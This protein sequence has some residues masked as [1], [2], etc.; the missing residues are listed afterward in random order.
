MRPAALL[1]AEKQ[2]ANQAAIHAGTPGISQGLPGAQKTPHG[3]L[4]GVREE[5]L[6]KLILRKASKKVE[7]HKFIRELQGPLH[8]CEPADS[9]QKHTFWAA[10][11]MSGCAAEGKSLTVLHEISET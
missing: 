3:I 9:C 6:V 1:G 11:T 2:A 5:L 4:A 10:L 8:G 7:P